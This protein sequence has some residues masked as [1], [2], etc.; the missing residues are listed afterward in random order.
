MRFSV[1]LSASVIGLTGCASLNGLSK[2]K[3]E[4]TNVAPA[5]V[6][7]VAPVWDEAAPE[8]LPTTDWVG[9]FSDGTLTQLVNEVLRHA[10]RRRRRGLKS[11]ELINCLA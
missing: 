11:R 7:P 3:P 9:S 10:L 5:Q 8:D 6:T 1:L 4:A 2:M